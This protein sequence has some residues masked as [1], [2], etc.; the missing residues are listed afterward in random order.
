MKLYLLWNP[1]FCKT[2]LHTLKILMMKAVLK[3]FIG[4]CLISCSLLACKKDVNSS[5]GSTDG[6][7]SPN[8]HIIQGT[9]FDAN[10]N[11]FKITN[12]AVTVGVWG[13]GDIGHDNNS[14][15]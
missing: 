2:I 12:A 5:T 7:G 9:I 3:K 13:P 1:V 10:G 8:A 6:S 14:Y 4:V 15:N 11:K